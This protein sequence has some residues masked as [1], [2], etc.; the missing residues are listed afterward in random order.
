[1]LTD[2]LLPCFARGPKQY[3]AW[4]KGL[5]P[6]RITYEPLSRLLTLG[7]AGDAHTAAYSVP[8]VPYRLGTDPAAYA[9]PEVPDGVPMCVLLID[10]D[11]AAAH[12]ATGGFGAVRADDAWWSALRLRLDAL[13]AAHPGAFCYRTRGGARI[14]FR[15]P[16][17]HIVCDGAGEIAWKRLYLRAVAYLAR[18]F[19]IVG[20]PSISDWPR[21]VRLPHVTRDGAF[22][23]AETLGDPRAVGEFDV[24]DDDPRDLAHARTLVAAIPA[25]APAL[26]ILAGN[27]TPTTRSARAA[28]PVE[29]RPAV[30]V[31]Q[32]GALG[33]LAVD[34]GRAL[35]RHHG[36]HG[37]HLALAGACYDR[38]VPLE[39]GPELA[40]AICAASGESDDRPQVWQTTADRVRSSQVVTGYGHL[41]RHWPDLAALVDAA[42]PSGGGARAI[43]EAL[44]A[45]DPPDELA[46]AEAAPVIRAAIE[47]AGPGLTVIRV[48][49]G[50]GKT[51]TAADVLRARAEACAE[52]ERIPSGRKTLYVAPSHAVAAEVAVRLR[53]V[54]GVYLRGILAARL[55]DNT[56]A[57]AYHVPLT[58]LSGARHAVQTWCD[59]L[60]MGRNGADAPCPRREGC[61]ARELA[62]VTLGGEGT[63]A[64]MVTVHALLAQG[65]AWAGGDALVVIDEDPQ[66]V[67][68]VA[69]SR[70]EVETAA[71]SEH[72]LARSERWRAPVLRALAAGLERGTIPTGERPLW[73]VVERGGEALLGDT[74]WCASVRDAYPA[75]GDDVLRPRD[76]LHTYAARA[77]WTSRTDD[78]GVTTWRRRA[79]WAPRLSRA[80][81]ARVFAG[82]A[83]ERAVEA[84][85][86][87]AL[88]ARLAAGVVRSVPAEGV[89]GH[90]ERGVAAVEVDPRDGSRRVLRG[91]MA[92]PAVAAALHRYG[93]TVL[94]DATAD[95]EL[96]GALAGGTVPVVDVRVADGAPVAR[97]LLYWAG[98][99]RRTA[100]DGAGVRW[101]E[102]VER[103]LRA[104]LAHAVDGG[105]RRIGVFS[106]KPLADCLR[107]AV[108]GDVGADPIAAAL[109]TDLRARGV[110]LVVG[111]YGHARGL[112]AW[113]DCDALVSLGDP[114]P[115]LGASRAVAAVLG[116]A[117]SA[118]EV[119]GRATAAEVSQVS[120]RLRAPWRTAPAVHVHVGTVAPA[121]WDR[122]AEVL[123]LPRGVAQGADAA[124]VADAVRVYGSARL[125]AAA[126]G[127]SRRTAEDHTA[128]ARKHLAASL[129]PTPQSNTLH[130]SKREAPCGVGNTLETQRFVYPA[131][132]AAGLIEAAGGAVAAADYLGVNRVAVYHWRAGRRPMPADAA[133][134][135]AG[136]LAE[137]AAPTPAATAP[138]PCSTPQRFAAP[139]IP[140]DHDDA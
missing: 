2:P 30:D 140:G 26:R 127:V 1:M 17:P 76:M 53:G 12:R 130:T 126:T 68:A 134:R 39:R 69:L 16:V 43:R 108:A 101:G 40:R 129:L 34:L 63:P 65:M 8:Q 61:E 75:E 111:H 87:H 73:E 97:R 25:W 119:Y 117:G 41:A 33:A 102:G 9:R 109:V 82:G 100:L 4:P 74:G 133:Q 23:R 123:E 28:R 81:H 27:V 86:V 18:A 42:L 85:R 88:V 64:V 114:R 14:I 95:A 91:V 48:T 38:G 107:A 113:A 90:P 93:P 66:A 106:W 103:Y 139:P 71:A 44:D 49:E 78:E 13:E 70:G 124:T 57:C 116:L 51:R 135:L 120:G 35:R 80:E 105:A 92:S 24:P 62:E 121:S 7:H 56:P 84:S 29:S 67:E 5:A 99:A 96:L 36:R 46:A 21:L 125:G 98:A 3:R 131:T 54:R 138:A 52:L 47:G 118:S 104:A 31:G 79:A 132:D 20:D 128:G 110:T 6:G 77:A 15:L 94:L 11:C 60:G 19:G 32:L 72:L 89:P 115:N 55:P 112:D 137:Q 22:A 37:V 58:R 83:S 59:G 45:R 122:R 10:V 50:A 136:A